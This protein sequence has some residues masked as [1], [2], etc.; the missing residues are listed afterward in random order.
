VRALL[1]VLLLVGIGAGAAAYHGMFYVTGS[2][3]YEACRQR[4][5]KE[6]IDGGFKDVEADNPSQA[7]LWGSCT[8]IMGESMEN[9]GFA[10]GSSSP[11]AT[12]DAKAL[13]S[14]CPDA[15][16]EM[17]VFPKF[18]YTVAVDAIEKNGGPSLIDRA[19][20]AGWLIE[21]P[22]KAR[23]PHCIDV[24]R[25][26]MLKLGKMPPSDDVLKATAR[27]SSRTLAKWVLKA[28]S[29]SEG[30]SVPAPCPTGSR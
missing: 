3:F 13:A 4:Q 18:W 19:A 28:S 17:P 8:P 24:A 22:M 21:R 27:P 26:Y 9:A 11:Q 6:K 1:A 23:W 14:A 5:A 7:A 30:Y 25:P 29:L 15:Y 16:T 12:E 10:I 20:P 2:Q